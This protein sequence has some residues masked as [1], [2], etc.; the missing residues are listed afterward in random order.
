MNALSHPIKEIPDFDRI[1]RLGP[2][3]A[4]HLTGVSDPAKS[5][6]IDALSSE[7]RARLIVTGSESGLQELYSDLQLYDGSVMIYPP[8]DLIFYEA[9]IHGSLGNSMRTACLRRL[10]GG[11]RVTV[12]TTAGSLLTPHMKPE[13]W[14]SHRI[15]FRPGDSHDMDLLAK[16][17][18]S[19][20]YLRSSM[21]EEPGQFAIRGGI[22]DIF[23]LTDENPV[24]VEF[25]GDEVDRISS[26]DPETQR[27]VGSLDEA[28]IYPAASLILT[29][30]DI[31]RGIA[32]IEKEAEKTVREMRT[33]FRTKEAHR[34]TEYVDS[35]KDSIG[36]MG[37]APGKGSIE[38]LIRYFHRDIAP[39]ISYFPEDTAV[40]FDEPARVE[41]ELRSVSAEFK[42][43][44]ERRE[45]AGAI[46]PGQ[47]KLLFSVKETLSSM[48]GMKVFMLSALDQ[49][50]GLRPADLKIDV[51]SRQTPSYNRDFLA[52]VRDLGRYSKEKYRVVLLT[53][54]HSRAKKLA[55]D[56]ADNG[57]RAVA[58]GDIE[59]P[60]V[61]GEV[62][63]LPGQLSHGFEFPLIG[64][65]VLTD[66]DIFGRR[67][68]KRVR[69]FDGGTRI[70]DVS[71]LRAGDYIVH[72][73][74]GLGIYRGIESVKVD[75]VLRDYMKLEYRDNGILYVPV[76]SLN[77]IQKYISGD[78]DAAPKLS[79]LGGQDWS[80]ARQ[81]AKES[82]YAVAKDLVK[83][84]S[85]R[86]KAEGYRY[87]HDTPWQREFE[88]SFPFEETEGQAAAIEETKKDMESGK[89]MDRL[90]LGDVGFGKTEVAIRAAFKAV[91]DN[92]QVAFLVPT[93]ILAQQHYSTFVERMKNYPVK[94]ELLSRFRTQTEQKKVV[95][96]LEK[97][98]VDIVVGTHRLLSKDV[99]FKDLGL[100]VIDEEQR[101]GVASK[102]K[103]KKIRNEVDVL[104][105]SA[106]PIPRTLHMS[107]SGIRD[108]SLLSEAPED[109]V[110]IQTFVTEYDEEIV[111]EAVSR[112]L[113]RGGQVYYV[114]NAIKDIHEVAENVRKA[115]PEAVVE[116]AHG[117]MEER[118]LE[119]I[120]YDFV[121]GN[122]DVLVSTTIVE[123]GLDI[124]NVNTIIV[125]SSERMGLSQLYQLRGRVGRSNRTAY[126]FLMYRRE[127]M[128][129]ETAEKRLE[130]IRE[131]TDLGSGY[132]IAMKDLEIRGAGT[133]LG[134]SQS[135]HMQA[136]GY[137]LYI[138]ML[139]SA[140]RDLR[141]EKPEK[142][143]ETSVDLKIDAFIPDDYISSRSVKLSVYREIAAARTAEQRLDTEEELKDR[144]GPIPKSVMNLLRISLI[145]EQAHSLFMTDVRGGDGRVV[146][147]FLKDA[148]LDPSRLPAVLKEAGGRL[149]L[150]L[151]GAPA[152]VFSYETQEDPA[153]DG[154]RLLSGL[155]HMLNICTVQLL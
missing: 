78:S 123:S 121:S 1:M 102:E 136:V 133:V 11:D 148:D 122:I 8:K 80:R 147:K 58:S 52:L 124:P 24:R 43:S 34:L 56:L 153:E 99:V 61:P 112:E 35:I 2:S 67:K 110:P 25:W 92:K 79:K 50:Q 37:Y 91:Q 132:R 81:K 19:T 117:R 73:S 46:L 75:N 83:L 131:F 26:F 76:N 27:S 87:S 125:D 103:I 94:I 100:L 71:D 62:E 55:E 20:G 134:H 7:K 68:K 108:M 54:S 84:Y 40:F 141:G 42:E 119:K 29:E 152:L 111:R 114:H 45:E 32:V 129:K 5:C 150:N 49:K 22:I 95:A 154:E 155:E 31:S 12:I 16:K 48:S 66:E 85:D 77:L 101:F 9:D 39:L 69:R 21:A 64:Y 140:V 15:V 105:L 72:E 118:E 88:D 18:V 3:S 116:Y 144:F 142:E 107:L 151:K 126:A 146:M 98:Q 93:T 44:M 149:S 90:I 115:V 63:V 33:A 138:R 74:H 128:L 109:R 145:R 53:A 51:S 70:R 82:A 104:T 14:A 4:V 137:D 13:D 41:E 113:K 89:V 106:T 97:G 38:S 139:N 130:A 96:A 17:L 143:F 135:G 30:E 57:V 127:R 86:L 59:R 47:K 10:V 120:M 65:S 23:G 60:L 6:L 28:V 36:D